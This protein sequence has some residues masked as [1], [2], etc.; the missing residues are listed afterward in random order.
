MSRKSSGS[1]AWL[2]HLVWDQRVAGSN[3][4]RSTRIRATLCIASEGLRRKVWGNRLLFEL[5]ALPCKRERKGSARTLR[6]LCRFRGLST[7]TS[8]PRS[9]R[10]KSSYFS[11]FRR[12]SAV[13]GEFPKIFEPNIGDMCRLR[14]YRQIRRRTVAGGQSQTTR[15][16]FGRKRGEARK[17]FAY[18]FPHSPDGSS[19]RARGELHA[20]GF[21]REFH[22]GEVASLV[23]LVHSGKL[24]P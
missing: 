13:F 9:N 24:C 18:L 17:Y 5:T 7:R 2:A 15:F 21:G 6:S 4:A 19:H 22:K 23:R 1:A 8:F 10:P 16:Q 3:P 12:F 11:G 20:A 14:Q